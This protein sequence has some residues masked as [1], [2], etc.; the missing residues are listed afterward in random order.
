MDVEHT[1]LLNLPHAGEEPRGHALPATALVRIAMHGPPTIRGTVVPPSGL[2]GLHP[3]AKL[4]AV[5]MRAEVAA[6]EP[7]PGHA[8]GGPRCRYGG[9]QDARGGAGRHLIR[10]DVQVREQLLALVAGPPGA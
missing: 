1:T 4:A 6:V 2:A 3:A 8:F 10:I 7:V 5:P 9:D